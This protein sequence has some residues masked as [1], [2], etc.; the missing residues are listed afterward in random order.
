MN[1]RLIRAI[2]DLAEGVVLTLVCSRITPPDR[3][4][5][6]VAC[7]L[8]VDAFRRRGLAVNVIEHP[9]LPTDL[10]RAEDPV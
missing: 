3:R 7:K 6:A 4:G 8:C 1:E 5:S 9:R 10:Y 2:Q